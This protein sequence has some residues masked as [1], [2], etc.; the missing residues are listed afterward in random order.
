[1]QVSH[2]KYSLMISYTLNLIPL[3]LTYR[4]LYY[5]LLKSRII[6]SW[7]F[8]IFQILLFFLRSNVTPNEIETWL[9][10]NADQFCVGF[11][12]FIC[13]LISSI[14]PACRICWEFNSNKT[15]VINDPLGQTHN[16]ASNGHCFLLFYF[17]RFEKWGR[18]Y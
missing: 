14:V 9:L 10:E 17:T 18:P 4:S 16:I 11:H 2:A 5:D 7:R 8:E 1:M 3:T 6:F 15:G 12:F 13:K